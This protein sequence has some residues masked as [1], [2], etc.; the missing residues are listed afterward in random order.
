[1]IINTVAMAADIQNNAAR[2]FRNGRNSVATPVWQG[3]DSERSARV[4][5]L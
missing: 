1:M 2:P 5:S 3:H 4:R